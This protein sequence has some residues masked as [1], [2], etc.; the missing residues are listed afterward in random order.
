MGTVYCTIIG[1]AK[2]NNSK[3]QKL[4]KQGM[5]NLTKVFRQLEKQN[6]TAMNFI[7]QTEHL[8]FS[9]QKGNLFNPNF[10]NTVFVIGH[11]GD[12]YSFL[13]TNK[14]IR[15]YLENMITNPCSVIFISCEL[16]K[17]HK[18]VKNYDKNAAKLV[19]KK[20]NKSYMKVFATK[21]KISPKQINASN[22]DVV[23]SC[24]YPNLNMTQLY[25]VSKTT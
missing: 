20:L 2:D 12:V 18:T 19:H 21:Y 7:T 15:L 8:T 22:F 10:V 5:D 17:E 11:G 9:Q 24:I 6:P 1:V 16:D 14:Y 23:N 13:D 4:V 25:D 3:D